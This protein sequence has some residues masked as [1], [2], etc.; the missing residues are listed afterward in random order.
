MEAAQ[1]IRKLVEQKL[2]ARRVEVP[3]GQ[4]ASFRC[5]VCE[6]TGWE[7]Y[8]DNAGRLWA[9]VCP[10]RASLP[11]QMVNCPEEFRSIGLDAIERH[12]G[13]TEQLAQLQ[14]WIPRGRDLYLHGGT[15]RGKT[16]TACA[17]VN[18][19][20]KP[21][22]FEVVDTL[23]RELVQ[24][25]EEGERWNTLRNVP[26]LVLDDIGVADT[27]WGRRTLTTVYAER[28]ARNRR[29]IFTS[30]KTVGELVKLWDD[31]RLGSRIVGAADIVQLE[32]PDYRRR[33]G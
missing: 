18:E 3:Q 17:L 33:R 23:L 14:R 10:C 25:D 1:S 22:R 28:L 16:M 4:D 29:T 20:R 19:L 8:R 11:V 32:G 24:Q 5:V 2:A 13:N 9:R 30:N 7:R 31:Q 6:D 26:V 27:D 15:G 12:N 21:A